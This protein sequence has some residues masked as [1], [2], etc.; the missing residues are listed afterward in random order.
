MG[1]LELLLIVLLVIGIAAILVSLSGH[2][3]ETKPAETDPYDRDLTEQ[4]KEYLRKAA[5]EYLSE[6]GENSLREQ[7]PGTG[8]LSGESSVPEEESIEAEKTEPEKNEPDK[9]EETGT[10]AAVPAADSSAG[11]NKKSRKKKRG[12]RKKGRDA[13]AFTEAST[14]LPESSP[15]EPSQKPEAPVMPA[16]GIPDIS[17]DNR[18]DSIMEMFHAGFSILEISKVVH[19]GVEVVKQVIDQHQG[20]NQE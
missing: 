6:E 9:E 11:D 16:A 17:G 14:E 4:E 12:K 19:E 3:G 13:A 7:I 10:G 5:R 15:A 18:D 8:S 2:S 20:E 1:T